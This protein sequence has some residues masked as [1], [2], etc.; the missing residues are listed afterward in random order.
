M[1]KMF[2]TDIFNLKNHL[3]STEPE[4]V[5]TGQA[6][7]GIRQLPIAKLIPFDNQPFRAYFPEKLQELAEDIRLH[8][9]LSPLLVRPILGKYQILAGHNRANAARLAGLETVPCIVKDVDEDAAKLILVNTNLNQRDELLPSEKAFAY[10]M[11][12][13]ALRRQGKRNDL[14]TNG[15]QVEDANNFGTNGAQVRSRDIVAQGS[16]ESRETVRRYIR[17]TYL[18][19]PLLDMVDAKALPFRAGVNISYLSDQE[20][21]LLHDYVSKLKLNINLD[22]SALLKYH[23]EKKEFGYAAMDE[24]FERNTKALKSKARAASVKLPYEKLS[25]YIAPEL[26]QKEAVDYI[27]KALEFYEKHKEQAK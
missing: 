13:E 3:D 22:Q 1:A 7:N 21:I 18:I 9:V 10:K 17:L 8:G 11:Q 26:P 25:R 20:Q 5:E 12:M 4:Q 24:V 15:A 2:S 6:D 16:G 27:M 19:K 23:S 14:G